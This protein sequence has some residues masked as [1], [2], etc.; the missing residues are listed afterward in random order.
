MVTQ[1]SPLRGEIS[2]QQLLAAAYVVQ[3]QRD[4]INLREA[5][6]DPTQVLVHIAETQ[7]LIQSRQL[8]LPAA[9]MLIAEQVEKITEA[10]GVAVGLVEGDELVYQACR[11]TAVGEMGSR[12]PLASGLSAYCLHSGQILQ[13]SDVRRDTR[14]RYELCRVR[15]V[16]SLIAVPVYHE[17]KIAA[18][19]E[20]RF[21]EANSFGEHDARSSQLMAGLVSDAIARASGLEWKQSLATERASMLEVLEKI[22]PQLE[23]LAEPF[24][25]QGQEES[26]LSND[27]ETEQNPSEVCR[28]CGHQFSEEEYFCGACGTARHEI[29]SRGDTQSKWASLWRIQQAQKQNGESLVAGEQQ[30]TESETT[31][32]PYPSAT[33]RT[34]EN[35]WDEES[36]MLEG[37]IGTRVGSSTNLVLREEPHGAWTTA[38]LLDL[39]K[40]P[41]L[42]GR[43]WFTAQ[44]HAHRGRVYIAVATLLLLCA[45]FDWGFPAPQIGAAGQTSTTR[46]QRKPKKP[47]LTFSEKLLVGMGIAEP[48]ASLDYL[49]NPQTQVWVDLH[50]ALYYCPGTDLYG[51]TEGG[52]LTTQKDAQLDQFEPASRR[53]CD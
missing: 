23:R 27:L 5:G 49:G 37:I 31:Q 41:R 38:R 2:F 7:K 22:K 32:S 12:V 52:K 10:N 48:P 39:V 44:W 13:C 16:L 6:A 21:A 47:E 26:V 11:G 4:G 30:V 28:G 40:A 14:V 25:A 45:I 43:L 46:G 34:L 42:P 50:T 20:V 29:S 35:V 9:T 51:K 53:A 17:G 8:D 19:L 3:Q 1:G 24:L 15:R 36:A 33:Q 18:V